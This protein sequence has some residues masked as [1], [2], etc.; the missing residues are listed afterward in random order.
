ML[1]RNRHGICLRAFSSFS[2]QVGQS[3]SILNWSRYLDRARNVVVGEA[4]LVGQKLDQVGVFLD[5]V[6]H[7][8]IM[9]GGDYTL[10]GGLAD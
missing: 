8:H 2:D 3:V 5:R 10:S 4:E 9:G 1:V 6:I 7:N